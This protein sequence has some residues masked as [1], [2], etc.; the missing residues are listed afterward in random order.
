[1]RPVDINRIFTLSTNIMEIMFGG[2]TIPREF[3]GLV[4]NYLKEHRFLI[5]FESTIDEDT[6]I[7]KEHY[8]SLLN[9]SAKL[10]ELSNYTGCMISIFAFEN[11]KT[12]PQYD[13]IK[14]E[15]PVLFLYHLRN[16][17][18]HGNKFNFYID[19]NRT[20][21]RDPG[22]IMWKNKIIERGLQDKIAYPDFISVGDIPYLFEDIS[23]IIEYI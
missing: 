7:S 2:L 23:K 21:F 3:K 4:E 14:H 17:S 16:A 20:R 13:N 22:T 18:A 15:I 12:L 6:H 19:K 10:T 8:L 9:D 5:S 1:M 11:L